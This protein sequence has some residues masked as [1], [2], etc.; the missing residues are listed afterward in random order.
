MLLIGIDGQLAVISPQ[1]ACAGDL[2]MLVFMRDKKTL[3]DRLKATV[4]DIFKVARG[5]PPAV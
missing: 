3:S 5:R 4:K 2:T 1:E